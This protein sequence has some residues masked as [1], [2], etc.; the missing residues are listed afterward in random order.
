MEEE[1]K[2]FQ[3]VDKRT[4]EKTARARS[5]RITL[6][7]LSS[8]GLFCGSLLSQE[9]LSLDLGPT[10][11]IQDDLIS[12]SLSN[13]ICKDLFSNKVTFTGSRDY[14]MDILVGKGTIQPSTV[15][16]LVGDRSR[17]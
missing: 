4:L 8:R 15:T 13:F 2:K 10:Q 14:D 7:C 17:I 1:A 3:H 9:R 12:S 16:E 5:I 11:I 6:I